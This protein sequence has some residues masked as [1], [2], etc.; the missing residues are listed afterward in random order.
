MTRPRWRP[1]L[2]ALVAAL[3]ATVLPGLVSPARVEAAPD[4]IIA[5]V[6]EGTGHGHGRGL[7]QWGA[8]G[9]AVDHGWD[10]RQ[11]LDHYYGGTS[12]GS[13]AANQ[14]ISVD[15]VA[16]RGRSA[17]GVISNGPGVQ[18]GGQTAPAMRAVHVGGNS[19]E[20]QRANQAVCDSSSALSVPD[21]P[22]TFG[23]SDSDGV[24]Q[25]QRFLSQFQDGSV[26][27]DGSWGPQTAGAMSG[28][29][30]ARG[31]PVNGERW[32]TDDAAEARRQI[33][34]AESVVWTVVGTHVQTTSNPVRFTTSGGDNSSTSA[35]N[36]L[37]L[38]SSS[39]SVSH[40]RG[41]IEV[42]RGASGNRVVND[43]LAEQYV[44]GVIPKEIS[45]SWADAGGGAG[46][47]SVRAQAVA[48]RSYGLSESRSYF[49][50][51]TSVQYASTCDTTSC[52]VYAGAD[53]EDPRTDAA[54]AATANVVRLWPNG[55]VVRTEFSASNGPRTAGGQFPAVNDIGDDTSRNPNHRWTRIIDA[56]SFAQQHGLGRITAATMQPSTS[57]QYRGFDGIWFDDVVITG[58]SGSFRQQAWDFRNANGLLSPGFT[59]RPI[60]RND[61]NA[62]FAFIGDSVGRGVTVSNSEF[63]RLIDGTFSNVHIDAVDS[64]CTARAACSGTSGVEAAAQ[65]P[66]GLD[67]VVVQLGYNDNPSSFASDIDAMMQALAARDVGQVMWV[68]LGERRS[69]VDYARSNRALAAA[70]GQWN[71]LSVL[72][73]QA[74]SDHSEAPRWYRSDG[75][76]LTTTGEAEFSLFMRDQILGDGSFRGGGGPSTDGGGFTPPP[77]APDHRLSPPERIELSLSDIPVSGSSGSLTSVPENVAAVAVN[78]TMVD[79]AGAGFSTVWPCDGERPVVSNANTTAQGQTV[80]NSVI[81]PVSP[82]GTVCF[83]S[84][85]G[86]DFIVDLS[87]WFPATGDST[88]FVAMEPVR[89]VDTRNG[90][91]GRSAAVTPN[92]PYEFAV[93]GLRGTTPDGDAVTIP[94]DAAAVSLNVTSANAAGSGFITVWP[95]GTDRPLASNVNLVEGGA[96]GNG[97]IAPIG[98]AGTVCLHSSTSTELIIDVAGYL[99]GGGASAFNAV[100]PRRV[101]DTRDATGAPQRRVTAATP[102]RVPVVGRSFTSVDGGTVTV[103]ADASAV[104]MNLTM[105]LPSS[106]GYATVWPCDASRPVASNVNFVRGQTRANSVLAPVGADGSVCVY[107]HVSSDVVVDIAGWF[108]GGTGSF[109]GTLPTRLV[110]TRVGL[111]PAPVR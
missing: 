68:N 60:T 55:S 25:I 57:S 31:L 102:I 59:V 73:W 63:S 28:W 109:V 29:Q 53:V 77:A 15:L 3:G 100:V 74:A 18:W 43:V 42:V 108:G 24:R 7:S 4:D 92:A 48:A 21:G 83:F 27:V 78:I 69:G 90:T 97:V 5:I 76:H 36:L 20:V 38:C 12:T 8:Y 105:V 70:S 51:G 10:W 17:V 16:H 80:A 50:P 67:L 14:R 32:D 84:S 75:V 2:L 89:H 64:R 106:S 52:Q 72:D 94:A 85:V 22:L 86:T 56:D 91:G 99:P 65:L 35:R 79:A 19:F 88:T 95:C 104:V 33:G 82:N 87:G 49:Y 93:A 11:I 26:V 98:D 101:V 37:G 46:V 66:S 62:S 6:I 81:A 110:D 41:A 96:V 61:V 54:V 71:N 44:R 40:Y 47:N 58:T 1:L 34:A 30:S 39:G 9:Y 111:G 45:A 13:T 103:G 107:S 23:S